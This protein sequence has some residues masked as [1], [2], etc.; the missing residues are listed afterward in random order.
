MKGLF[1]ICK[2]GFWGVVF[3][4]STR[5]SKDKRVSYTVHIVKVIM[6]LV[7]IDTI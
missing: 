7:Y 1:E 4:C 2:L 6:I 5:G 3:P